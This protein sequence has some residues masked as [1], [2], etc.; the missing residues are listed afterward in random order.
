MIET[1]SANGK[2]EKSIAIA[3]YTGRE[4]Y[5][6][7]TVDIVGSRNGNYYQLL[8]ISIKRAKLTRIVLGIF[9]TYSI[10]V[11]DC[12]HKTSYLNIAKQSK[13]KQS[14]ARQNKAAC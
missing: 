11:A 12:N 13:A 1:T 4:E 6:D 10:T 3:N 2:G 8:C 7:A 5:L 14:V 9:M